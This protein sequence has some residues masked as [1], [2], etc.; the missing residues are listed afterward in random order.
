MRKSLLVMAVFSVITVSVGYKLTALTI[1]E[2][3]VYVGE[4]MIS[5]QWL[6]VEEAVTGPVA[7]VASLAPPIVEVPTP[8]IVIVAPGDSLTLIAERHLT[9]YKRLFDANPGIV[10]PNI[11]SVGQAIRIPVVDELIPSRELP[12]IVNTPIVPK[13]SA[14]QASSVPTVASGSVWDQ[15][16]RCESGGNWA[17]NTGN[18]YY[19][20]LQ[21]SLSTWRAVGGSGLPSENSRDE[22][23]ARAEI[24]LARSGWGQWPAC[25]KMLGLR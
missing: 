16:A 3:E 7:V 14:A 22:Q 20:G 21:F 11:I 2:P 25:T 23:I 1:A 8:I 12:V 24:L 17:I 9:T 18:G 19:G 5:P 4:S 10:N 13:S 6:K 15:L